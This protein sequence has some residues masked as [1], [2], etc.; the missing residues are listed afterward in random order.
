MG[1]HRHAPVEIGLQ[2][3]PARGCG[4]QGKDDVHGGPTR[5]RRE[6]STSSAGHEASRASLIVSLA[7]SGSPN[8][9]A[10]TGAKVDFPLPGG[11]DT[12]RYKRSLV[13]GAGDPRPTERG[14]AVL[15]TSTAQSAPCATEFGTLPR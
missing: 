2:H 11:P 7:N 6:P 13:P 5:D 9:P 10:R 15:T 14:Q 4:R 3:R 8:A 12:T 1:N